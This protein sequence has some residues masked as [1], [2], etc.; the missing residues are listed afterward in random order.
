MNVKTCPFRG[1]L[2]SANCVNN[3][4]EEEPMKKRQPSPPGEPVQVFLHLTMVVTIAAALV[5]GATSV[6]ANGGHWAHNG[7]HG[8]HGGVCSKTAQIAFIACGKDVEDNYL[9]AT[10]K[11]INFTDDDEKYDCFDEA[12]ETRK[13]ERENC[14]DVRGARL[15]VCDTLTIGDGPYDPLS[16]LDPDDF[17]KAEEIEGNKYFPLIPG[18]KMIYKNTEGEKITVEV[19]DE[20]TEIQGFPVRV[21]ID[22]VEVRDEEGH[23][24]VVEDTIDW[25]A[26][27]NDGTVWYFGETTL[28]ADE[29]SMLLDNDGS[30]QAGV[31]GAQPGIIMRE[32]PEDQEVYRQEWLL[33][34]AE[35]VAKT[36]STAADTPDILPEVLPEN[37]D[38]NGNCIETLD[39]TPIEPGVYE[40]KFYAPGVGV[41][42]VTVD[43]DPDFKEW[44]VKIIQK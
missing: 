35:D 24:V 23:W 2:G 17:K 40:H 30:W 32:V 18:K 21:V 14:G 43:D 19:T 12:K 25:F 13:D 31:D 33:E 28:A 7:G 29:E 1:A 10:A 39:Y 42:V 22:V 3:H 4:K 20:T 11:C 9:I 34:D 16:Y 15:E 37:V 6:W 26:Q 44:L 27:D 8:K 38:C 5:L 36:L 41:V